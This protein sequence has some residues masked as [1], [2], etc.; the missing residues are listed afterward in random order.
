MPVMTR[1][2]A[3]AAS[4][5]RDLEARRGVHVRTV[6]RSRKP[7]RAAD[8][9]V[10]RSPEEVKKAARSV[11]RR[12]GNS[13][14]T[15]GERHISS[16]CDDL[17]LQIF[18]H[19]P[20]AA[21]L[22]RAACACPAWR[23]GMASSPDFRRRFRSL[24][25]S[26]L[27]GLFTSDASSS[28]VAAGSPTT[29][30]PTLPHDGDDDL[31][32]AAV[33]GGDLSLTSLPAGG[34]RVIS[35]S[36][37]LGNLLLHNREVQSLA[38]I[39][40]MSRQP[41]SECEGGRRVLD[42]ASRKNTLGGGHFIGAVLSSQDSSSSSSPS[43]RRVMLVDHAGS[44]MKATI[45]SMDTWEVS[46]AA[47]VTP[48]VDVPALPDRVD[49]HAPHGVAVELNG[50]VY[51]VLEN[52]GHIVS[53]DTTTMEFAVIEL[54]ECVSR[55]SLGVGETKDGTTCLVYSDGRDVGVL[56]HTREEDGDAHGLRNG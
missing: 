36:C 24:H 11:R 21:T 52:Y 2:Q 9:V 1:S 44:K 35:N 33:H 23:R 41:T 38:V 55:K 40:P 31:A 43:S 26:P 19:L 12:R 8:V 56:M 14:A 29:F 10:A 6:V 15:A 16:L 51:Y 20:S 46:S 50:S 3:A 17:L 42:L 22:V 34:W 5:R 37:R 30:V 47:A 4:R 39:N 27:L 45:Y 54:P 49:G 13:K 53:I 32:A 18:L 48:W 28:I 7:R 25:P